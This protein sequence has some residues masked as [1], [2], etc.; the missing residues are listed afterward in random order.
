MFWKR[1]GGITTLRE[2]I[3]R[4]S[5]LENGLAAEVKFLYWTAR[6]EAWIL[7]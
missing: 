6:H 3:N 5:Y 4:K 7:V 2:E 1:S